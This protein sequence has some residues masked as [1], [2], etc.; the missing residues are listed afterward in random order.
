MIL[1]R[2]F[3]YLILYCLCGVASVAISS[4]TLHFHVLDVGEGQSVLLH[5]NNKAI[6][7][8]TGHA[9]MVE[10]VLKRMDTLGVKQLDYLFLTHLHADHASGYFRIREQFPQMITL[11]GCYSV[12]AGRESDMERWIDTALMHNPNRRC[13][14][15]GDRIEWQGSELE[16]LWPGPKTAV[17]KGLNHNSV[18]LQIRRGNRTILIMGDADKKA[19]SLIM[20]HKQLQPVDILVVGHHGAADASSEAFLNAVKPKTAVVSVNSGNFRGYP[21]RKTL[22]RLNQNSELLHITSESGEFHAVLE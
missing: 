21:D 15:Q 2:L 7:V 4:E 13:V 10:S 17:E 3:L 12:K 20:Q 11:D 19:E 18:V 8:D 9:G 22:G 5:S 14:T 16:V 1:G 6:L